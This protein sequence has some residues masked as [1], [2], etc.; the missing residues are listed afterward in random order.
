MPSEL[1]MRE[2]S[3]TA[4]NRR[5]VEHVIMG[6]HDYHLTVD[7]AL[8]T[9][10]RVDDFFASVP[11]GYTLDD[12]SCLGFFAGDDIAGIGGV[13]RRWNAPNKAII[14]LLLFHPDFRRRGFGAAAVARIEAQART[15]PGIDRLRIGV[16]TTNADAMPFWEAQGFVRNG[17]IKPGGDH[18]TG[19]IVIFEKPLY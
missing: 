18:F 3:D 6:S 7:G 19:D 9:N 4:A 13:L 2:L 17:E 14:G 11:P 15:W 10:E 5:L 16:V 8:P 1:I 12:L